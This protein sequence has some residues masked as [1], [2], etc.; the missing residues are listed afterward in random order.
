MNKKMKV[1]YRFTIFDSKWIEG[2]N[3]LY[4]AIIT[5]KVA[6]DSVYNNMLKQQYVVRNVEYRRNQKQ[7]GG[8]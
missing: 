8:F 2:I 7:L 3:R 6:N 4:N 1:N 5:L